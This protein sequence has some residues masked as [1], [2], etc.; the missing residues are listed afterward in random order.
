QV[1]LNMEKRIQIQKPI[2]NKYL[3]AEISYHDDPPADNLSRELKAYSISII[4]TIKDLLKLNPLFK[5]ELQIFLGH[6]DFTEPGRLADFAVALTTATRDELQEVLETFDVEKRIDR[7]LMLLKKEL[8]ISK[9]QSTINQKIEATISKAQ[10]EFFLKEQLKAIKKELGMEKDD[11]TVEIEKFEE[12]L[13]G[14]QVPDEAMKVIREELDKLSSLEV[15]SAEYGVVR[16]YIDWLTIVPWGIYSE[17]THD[18][19]KA[20]K[21]LEQDHYGLKDIKERILEFIG[22]GKLTGGVKG[23]I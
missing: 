11:K 13:K 17:E 6:S 7:A 5:E 4:S 2:K 14:R 10:R 12:R 19:K 22:V 3:L 1:V 8:D 20:E 21:I 18:V 23:S 15:Q 16:N 9:L